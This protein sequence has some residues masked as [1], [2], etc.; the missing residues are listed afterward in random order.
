MGVQVP[1]RAPGNRRL[2]GA[3]G[4]P[5]AVGLLREADE[6]SEQVPPG[7][8]PDAL[9]VDRGGSKS[10]AALRRR[11]RLTCLA[12]SVGLQLSAS[13]PKG[14]RPRSKSL[15]VHNAESVSR[16]WGE[17]NGFLSSAVKVADDWI[18]R[19]RLCAQ[20]SKLGDDFVERA[21]PTQTEFL[22]GLRFTSIQSE[23]DRRAVPGRRTTRVQGWQNPSARASSA[24]NGPTLCSCVRPRGAR[25]S[26]TSPKRCWRCPTRRNSRSACRSGQRR[27]WF[28]R[29]L[30]TL[31]MSG[32]PRG[33]A[34]PGA[35]RCTC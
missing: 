19:R 30:R 32:T 2:P 29:R 27:G 35:I 20:V 9:C 16:R 23:H 3:L 14:M 10:P 34:A 17:R 1:P 8:R 6:A 31:D 18:G 13:S 21:Q 15:L 22:S 25:D 11:T 12:H 5:P 4:G 26:G 24:R 33:S 28:R 7:L